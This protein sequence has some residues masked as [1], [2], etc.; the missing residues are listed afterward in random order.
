M[1]NLMLTPWTSAVVSIHD[2]AYLSFGSIRIADSPCYTVSQ[3]LAS[4]VLQLL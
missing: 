2:V 1:L 4:S 3:A